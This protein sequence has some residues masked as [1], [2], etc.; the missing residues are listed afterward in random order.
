MSRDVC[1]E[2]LC[3]K[4]PMVLRRDSPMKAAIISGS[5]K[6]MTIEDVEI[7]NPVDR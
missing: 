3:P 7:A 1:S 2:R 4:W 5:L 6:P